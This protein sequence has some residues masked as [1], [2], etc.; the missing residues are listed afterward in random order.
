MYLT[1]AQVSLHQ[2]LVDDL[3]GQYGRQQRTEGRRRDA[4]Q[5]QQELARIGLEIGK[6]PLQQRA[7]HLRLIGLLLLGHEPP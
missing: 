1:R 3:P 5:Y 7:C 4:Q 6:H 2:A